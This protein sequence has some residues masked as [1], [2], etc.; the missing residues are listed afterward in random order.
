VISAGQGS[1][2]VLSTYNYIQKWN[3]N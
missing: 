2:A 1:I 3:L